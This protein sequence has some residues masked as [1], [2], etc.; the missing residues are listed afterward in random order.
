[1]PRPDRRLVVTAAALV[2]SAAAVVGWAVTRG[3]DTETE[4]RPAASAT[5]SPTPS[6]T[7]RSLDASSTGFVPNRIEI[8]AIDVAAS[9]VDLGRAADGSQEVP[10]ALDV[11]GWWRDGSQVGGPGSAAI[12]GHTSSSGGAVF[13]RLGELEP[14]DRVG[15]DGA[16][17]ERAEFVVRR[18][19]SVPVEEFA[20]VA[21]RV[22]A[23]SG[24]RLLA[25]MT[26]GDFDGSAFT[27]TVIAWATPDRS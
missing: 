15:V 25:V 18:V 2:L 6:A 19:E 11:A 14:G 26:C 16:D 10:E 5:G 23:R 1:M 21:S 7:P 17:G 3:G 13:D 20:R 8:D 27:T 12:V 4:P 22:Y 24:P 9:V